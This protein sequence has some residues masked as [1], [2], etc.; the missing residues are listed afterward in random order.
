[1]A[2]T[3]ATYIYETIPP[4]PDEPPCR[5]EVRQSMNDQPLTRHPETGAAIRRV[6]TGGFGFMG[7]S[8]PEPVKRLPPAR[9]GGCCG[10][11]CRGH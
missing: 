9:G 3:M 5:F 4:T 2:S 7:I 11:C 10:G 1:M 8:K 6:I